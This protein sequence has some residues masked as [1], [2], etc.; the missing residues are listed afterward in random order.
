MKRSFGTL[1]AALIVVGAV[2]SVFAS[3]NQENRAEAPTQVG[4][5]NFNATGYP[6]VNEKVTLRALVQNNPQHPSDLNTTA[7]MKRTEALTNVHIEW[8]MPGAGFA[9]KK[10]LMLATGDLPDFF[11][12]GLTATELSKFGGDG[13][14]IPMQDLVAKYA[15]NINKIFAKVP[16]LKGFSTAP[17]GNL[18]GIPRINGGMWMKATGVAVINTAW[19]A[20]LGLSMPTTTEEFR[21]VLR[22][23]KTADPNKNGKADEIPIV[24]SGTLSGRWGFNAIM[25]AFGIAVAPNYLDVSNGK[26]VCTA[27]SDAF[28]KSIEYIAGLSSE[29]LLDPEGFTQ[30]NQQQTA[31]VSQEPFVAGY[32][33]IW[34]RDVDFSNANAMKDYAF[35]PLLQ[36]PGGTKPVFYEVP[37][38]GIMRGAGAITKASKHPEVAMRWIDY[39]YDETVSFEMGEG[40]IGVRLI[41][42]PDGTLQI[43]PPPA[44]QDSQTFRNS[45][46]PG[47]SGLW[48]ILPEGYTKLRNVGTDAKVGYMQKSLFPVSDTDAF[49]GVFYTIQESEKISMIEKTIIQYIE[50][51][52]SEWIMAGKI[53]NWDAYLAEL[54]KMGI[55]EWLSINQ[56]AYGRFLKAA[57]LKL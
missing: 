8:I 19:L 55:D 9:E 28:R 11:M 43:G 51:V 36:G 35:M 22:K 1:A 33:Q 39:C 3:G 4:E 44:G 45:L 15:P 32:M 17:D 56:D 29:G 53:G 47:G 49:P 37:F 50:R 31:K 42:Q 24:F 7:L 34:D 20:N 16:G 30:N 2:S 5:K 41:K 54:K 27:T 18:Y 14:L 48:A 26:V 6:I 23:F 10:S 46:A 38:S 13:S 57:N 21:S 52:S 25:S 40:D 12:T